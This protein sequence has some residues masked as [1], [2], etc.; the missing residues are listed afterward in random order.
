HHYFGPK[1]HVFVA[2]LDLPFDPGA[3]VPQLLA[4][5]P[6][7]M[8]ER[9]ARFF[10]QVWEDPEL[11]PRMLAL[12]R[13]ILA[14]D[15]AAGLI[16]DFMTTELV[17]RVARDLDAPDAELRANLCA[18]QLMGLAFTRYVLHMEPMASTDVE[19]LVGAVG[20][21]L[22]RYLGGGR[23]EPGNPG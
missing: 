10:F 15:P 22:Q 1:Q 13:T 21:T 7:G 14:G 2:A 12:L 18:A 3:L 5:G 6:D 9:L 8:G 11:Q 17:G 20:P 4:D 16:R 23:E 19:T